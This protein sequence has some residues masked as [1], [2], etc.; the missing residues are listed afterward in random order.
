LYFVLFKCKATD[1]I[2]NN[3][4][5]YIEIKS[6]P[7][8]LHNDNV[9]IPVLYQ[10]SSLTKRL[11][12]LSIYVEHVFYRKNVA[13][14]RRHWYCQNTSNIQILNVHV[15]LH[16]SIAYASDNQ[17]NLRSWPIETGQLKIIMFENEQ[18][19]ENY[20]IKQIQYT[21]RFL[22]VYERPKMYSIR[23]NP[24]IYKTNDEF[25]SK[26]SGEKINSTKN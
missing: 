12:T 25:C 11:I 22:S 4:S 5:D 13:I 1:E 19:D 2:T 18:Q 21:V 8:V 17:L 10:C 20:I 23:Q 15:K 3:L 14:F 9:Y 16:R 24:L 6:I 7:S 26:E